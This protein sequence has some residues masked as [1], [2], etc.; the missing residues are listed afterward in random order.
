MTGGY[1]GSSMFYMVLVFLSLYVIGMGAY[2]AV[3][4][5]R[6]LRDRKRDERLGK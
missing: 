4:K 3:Q 1:S 2:L 5:I 6:K